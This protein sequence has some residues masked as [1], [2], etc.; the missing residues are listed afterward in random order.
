M[1]LIT[2]FKHENELKKKQVGFNSTSQS[3]YYLTAQMLKQEKNT[4]M[5]NDGD[6]PMFISLE[7]K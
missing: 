6:N 3:Y 4:H 7:A 1:F 5:I 2:M